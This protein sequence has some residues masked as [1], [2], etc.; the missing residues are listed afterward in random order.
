MGKGGYRFRLKMSV[1]GIPLSVPAKM[2]PL[3]AETFIEKPKLMK[4]DL[5]GNAVS[6]KQSVSKESYEKYLKTNNPADLEPMAG[7]GT[8]VT[9]NSQGHVVDEKD[10][11]TWYVD[12]TGKE[13]EVD[14]LDPTIGGGKE[15]EILKTPDVSVKDQ[16]LIEKTYTLTCDP[17]DA[18]ALYKIAEELEKEGQMGVVD[19]VFGESFDKYVG[20][21]VPTIDRTQG[22]FSITVYITRTKVHPDWMDITAPK[23]E[24]LVPA[25]KK[26]KKGIKLPGAEEM[27]S[28]PLDWFEH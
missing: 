9:L 14:P 8:M 7:R 13:V 4:K 5:Q 12:E 15:V 6:G 17:L 22:K 3:R 2:S 27:F 19:I 20:M 18:P 11:Q 1:G 23:V 21:V 28:S 10:I 26:P 16:Y 25:G 24:P